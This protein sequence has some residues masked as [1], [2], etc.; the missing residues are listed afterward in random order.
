ML[1]NVSMTNTSSAYKL[2]DMPKFI[3]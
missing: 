3:F 1:P 2:I